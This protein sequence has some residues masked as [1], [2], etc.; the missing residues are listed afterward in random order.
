MSNRGIN[1]Q[2]SPLAAASERSGR[3][4]ARNKEAGD[5]AFDLYRLYMHQERQ[6]VL[7]RFFRDIGLD[8]L[9][10]LRV[11]DVGC[12]SGGHLRRLVDYGAEP[13]NCY[14]IDPCSKSIAAARELNPN[15]SF[16]EGSA[17]QLPFHDNDFDLI[18]QFTVLTS[19][20]D[21]GIRNSIAAEV[22]RVLRPGGYFI[23]YDFAFSNPRNPNVRGIS[24]REISELLSG[25]RLKFLRV[26]LAPPIG[27]AIVKVFPSLYW[28]LR[29]IPL[30]RT[31]YFCFAQKL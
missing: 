1:L 22:R 11:L 28:I 9:R 26:T 27:R 15:I 31:H 6:E 30:L 10:G 18:F 16:V 4:I 17:A 3:G 12:G 20:L 24:R 13:A 7:L 25:F 29:A 23:W 8:T 14:G 19:V 21:A 5:S 2:S